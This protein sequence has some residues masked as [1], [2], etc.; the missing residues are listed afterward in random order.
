VSR[1][2]IAYTKNSPDLKGLWNGAAW[3]QAAVLAINYFRP[4]SS[5]HRP[6]TRARLLF[7][8]AYLYGIF[9]VDDYYVR[10]VH[11]RFQ[12][13]TY[14]DSCVEIFMQPDPNQG[15]FNF[16]FNAGGA[17]AVFYIRDSVRTESGFKSFT[18]LS[19]TQGEQVGIFHSQPALIDPERVGALTWTLEFAIPLAVLAQYAEFPSAL[20]GQ[21]WHG[22]LFKCGDQT[23]HPH[24]ASWAPVDELN[25]HLP[26]CFGELYFEGRASE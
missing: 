14:L 19:E 1:Y 18:K 22:N 12:G 16:E 26:R 15:Y 9:Q 24:W 5:S 13:P 4:E 2:N 23:S 20:A 8:D 17:L 25:F 3:Q 7:D 11:T 6:P 10:S 21:T